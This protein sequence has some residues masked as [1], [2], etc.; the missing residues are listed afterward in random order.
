MMHAEGVCTLGAVVTISMSIRELDVKPRV[1]PLK[2]GSIGD[3][4]ATTSSVQLL[5][6]A[7]SR[8][9]ALA[10]WGDIGYGGLDEIKKLALERRNPFLGDKEI[11][12]N[13]SFE[14]DSKG[15]EEENNLS[16]DEMSSLES[17]ASILNKYG[18]VQNGIKATDTEE[19]QSNKVALK[20]DPSI[21][22]VKCKIPKSI[23]ITE[24]G[25]F[26]KYFIERDVS[27]GLERPVKYDPSLQGG[28]RG[29]V[30]SQSGQARGARRQRGRK[31]EDPPV[32]KMKPASSVAS[33]KP[34]KRVSEVSHM[35]MFSPLKRREDALKQV[36][37]AS[38][39]KKPIGGETTQE[40][41][42]TATEL[43][44]PVS[45]SRRSPRLPG[46]GELTAGSPPLERAPR[47]SRVA[48]SVDALEGPLA[49]KAGELSAPE[50]WPL[51]DRERDTSGIILQL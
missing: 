31:R 41:S 18:G 46:E 19:Q 42:T 33:R 2:S 23:D 8:P 25:S 48:R 38:G 22:S 14:F 13:Y 5:P 30:D 12:A 6:A 35:L 36:R 21:S 4:A 32:N 51:S 7:P 10:E 29:R 34:P 11:D 28:L 40:P 17:F 45:S 43:V 20:S 37:K 49:S 44:S 1:I 15:E 47:R 50:W 27:N 24:E 26:V 3:I 16:E 9:V 39:K